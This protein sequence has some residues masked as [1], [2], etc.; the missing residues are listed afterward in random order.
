MLKKLGRI[1]KYFREGKK[2]ASETEALLNCLE[3][4]D[5]G[6]Y[7]AHCL[8]FDIVAQGETADDARKRLA[9]LIKEQIIF[10]TERD[11]EEK[12]LFHPA[13][14]KYWEILHHLRTRQARKILLEDDP[15][16]ITTKDILG[17]MESTNAS[18]AGQTA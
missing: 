3:Y 11:I 15:R 5:G 13:P 9:G 6:C 12:A 4:R 16:H 1:R 17:C 2:C 10:T 7:I 8:E 14:S 18:L